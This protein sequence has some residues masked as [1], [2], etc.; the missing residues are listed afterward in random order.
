MTYSETMLAASVNITQITLQDAAT[1]TAVGSLALTNGCMD[2][3]CDLC[4][5]L[6]TTC[7]ECHPS[8]TLHQN[9]TCVDECDDGWYK[10][11]SN[12]IHAC[13]RCHSTCSTCNG[14]AAADCDTCESSLTLRPDGTCTFVCD[15]QNA[16][17]SNGVVVAD[18]SLLVNRVLAGGIGATDVDQFES[19]VAVVLAASGNTNGAVTGATQVA[20][21]TYEGE[22][23]AIFTFQVTVDQSYYETITAAIGT[24]VSDGSLL[25]QL[26]LDI[27]TKFNNA[28]VTQLT[29]AATVGTGTMCHSCHN[30][31][32]TCSGTSSDECTSCATNLL[33]MDHT[34][35]AACPTGYM[36]S[37]GSCIACI[38]D[39]DV[40]SSAT[41]CT[42]CAT[43]M[44]LSSGLCYDPSYNVTFISTDDLNTVAISLSTQDLSAIQ[45]ND[46][47]ATGRTNTYLTHSSFAFTDM[48]AN[49]ATAIDDGSGIIAL[50]YTTDDSQPR[51][52]SFSL[53]MDL[54]L[55]QLTFSQTVETNLV[56][57]TAFGLQSASQAVTPTADTLVTLTGGSVT[58]DTQGLNMVDQTRVT[59]SLTTAD[60][61]T[62]KKKTAVATATSTTFVVLDG[63]GVFDLG[64]NSAHNITTSA[65]L[66]ASAFV[67]DTTAPVLDDVQI[68]LDAMT[69]SLTF[70]ETVDV[71]TFDATALQLQGTADVADS[72]PVSLTGNASRSGD[73][74]T[75]V[76]MSFNTADTNTM[77]LLDSVARNASTTFVAFS[78]ALID[79]MNGNNVIARASS[80]GLQVSDFAT[81]DTAPTLVTS[82]L[83]LNDGTLMISFTEPVRITSL[84]IAS[85]QLAPGSTGA[86][87]AIDGDSTAIT[88]T[89]GLSVQFQIGEQDLN[90][91]MARDDLATSAGTTSVIVTSVIDDMAGNGAT[92]DRVAIGDYVPDT[93]GPVMVSSTIDMTA[94]TLTITF[95]ETVNASSFDPTRITI[96]SATQDY[97]LTGA[98]TG[99]TYSTVVTLALLDV[100]LDEIKVLTELATAASNTLVNAAVGAV[101]DMAGVRNTVAVPSLIQVTNF[102]EDSTAPTLVAAVLDMNTLTAHL[103]FSETVNASSLVVARVIIQ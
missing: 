49:F 16:F 41:V 64:G 1:A 100:D 70:S 14:G 61:N 103:R 9:R 99:A 8:K 85:V 71:S 12:G 15:A 46:V 87:F 72:T 37:S 42:Q 45:K 91:I 44:M 57:P 23:S 102:T 4:N 67:Q 20:T 63:S 29:A 17:R 101:R 31:C 86:P 26:K 74:S 96:S 80:E 58:T 77:K 51:L 93:T 10:A 22:E 19:T 54:A 25:D 38:A 92:G 27:P 55:L 89:S 24:I 76:V 98:A 81:D 11:T 90:A 65:A 5:G 73:D 35:I 2:A 36:E 40:C 13:N 62:L 30:S 33:A 59:I 83:N 21:T 39:C 78:S 3:D 53:D 84:A 18:A 48:N 95:T 97:T 75:V 68:D 82:T 52:R 6:P 88:T 79:D 56:V 28:N 60:M 69:L 50:S 47:L 34:C 43:G 7:V 66:E 94:E 32:N